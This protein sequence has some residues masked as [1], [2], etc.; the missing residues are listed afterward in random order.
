LGT[1]AEQVVYVKGVK[2]PE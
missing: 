1:Q 2:K